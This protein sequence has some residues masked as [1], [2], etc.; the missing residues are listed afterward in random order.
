[1]GEADATFTGHTHEGSG[2]N[3]KRRGQQKFYGQAGTYLQSSRYGKSLG[4]TGATAE[5]PGVILWPGTKKFL[6]FN[7][8]FTDGITH[9]RAVRG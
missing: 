5:M 6:G 4:F 3:T 9:L 8:A 7:D 1:M 2:E